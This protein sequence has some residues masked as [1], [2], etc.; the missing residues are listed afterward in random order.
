MTTL[1][2]KV[3]FLPNTPGVYQFFD[4]SG[5]VIYVGKAKDLKKRVSSYFTSRADENR[6]LQVLVRKIVDIKHIVTT[7]E[8]D[9]LLLENNLIKKLQP[10]YNVLLKDDKTYPWICIKS[11]MFPRIFLTRRQIKDG[12][13]YFGPYTSV[14]I[15]RSLLETIH[16]LYQLR[17]CALNLSLESIAKHKHK[18]CLKYH[19][20]NCKGPCE[21]MQSEEEYSESI[22][23][24][25]SIIRGN[26]GEV[27]KH[28]K[29]KMIS[30][31]EDLRFE[32]AQEIKEQLI[33]LENYQSKSVV[34]NPTIND[35]DVFSLVLDVGVAYANFLRIVKGSII[36]SQTF[37]L[38]LGLDE[39]KEELL[40]F[41]LAEI[42][43]RFNGL[44][45]EIIVSFL[46]DQEPDN[47]IFTI[48]KKGDKLKLLEMSEQ[49][50]KAY[51]LERMKQLEQLSPDKHAE[52][53]LLVIKQDLHLPK[54]PHRIE[55]FD[56]SNI[57]GTNPVAA[58]VVFI[59]G[60]PS[61][62]DYRHFNVKTVE[63]PND[64]DS[65]E[66][67]VF[68]RYKRVLEEDKELPD[69]IVI[70]GGKGQ[71]HAA[72]NSLNKLDLSGKIP[73]LS[74]AERLEEIYFPGDPTPLHLNKNS[75]TLKVLMHVRDEA[76]RFG[77]K[78]HRD[79]RS[80]NF[81]KSELET[82]PGIGE[83]TIIKL[84][85]H[86]KS[87]SKI[88]EASDVDLYL[89]AGKRAGG[90]IYNYFKNSENIQEDQYDDPNP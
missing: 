10:R 34:V 69:L 4:S 80:I 39:T 12:S 9:A 5:T 67:I 87:V 66:E 41:V 15:V 11:E 75:E 64:Y 37:E 44:S 17:S 49:N 21:G 16:Q 50:A 40:S 35:V 30:A 83:K 70:D 47:K 71:L 3:S 61:K 85:T 36:Q 28:L 82:I 56:N 72:L 81:I 46:P 20:G 7:N 19:I 6:K 52:R 51:R 63:G 43:E 55:C 90:I 88:K 14:S 86:F 58:C 74:L 48:P 29:S 45:K 38:K 65:M 77:L 26:A 89:V 78:F 2:E 23:M 42:H 53:I 57:Q 18:V 79:K 24:A 32:E 13:R 25:T 27:I 59:D 8:S 76:H 31:V 68:R 1:K 60:K 73:I 22:T 62:K 33:L 84:M 54:L